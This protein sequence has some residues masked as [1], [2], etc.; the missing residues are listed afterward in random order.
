MAL[1]IFC[2]V[3]CGVGIVKSPYRG[4]EPIVCAACNGKG[5]RSFCTRPLRSDVGGVTYWFD[6]SMLS[7]FI[8]AARKTVAAWNIDLEFDGRRHSE[9]DCAVSTLSDALEAGEENL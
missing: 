2:S 3:C 1:S 9:M 5:E 8:R 7:E 4:I 6:R